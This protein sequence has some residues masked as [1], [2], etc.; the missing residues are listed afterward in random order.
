MAEMSDLKVVV[1]GLPFEATV[2]D[3]VEHFGIRENQLNLPVWSDSGR[4]KGVGFITCDHAEQKEE[5]ERFDGTQFTASD[6]T[7]ELSIR[8][9][10]E[11]PPR[12]GAQRGGG[13]KRRGRGGRGGGTRGS[14]PGAQSY[15]ANEETEREIYVS[16]ASF[17]TT[18][19][20]FIQFFKDCGE[21]EEVTIPTLYSTGKPKGFAFVRFATVDARNKALDKNGVQLDG[22]AL[23]IRENKGRAQ[24]ATR[25]MNERR[26]T[27]LSSKPPGCTTIYV[28]N[29]PWSTEEKDLQEMFEDCGEIKSKRIVRQS[30]T[31]RSRGF[32]YVEFEEEASVDTAV[33]KQLTVD[34]RDLRL[35]YAE[36]LNVN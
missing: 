24:R 5:I 33:Q 26:A 17:D 21:V 20:G 14:G 22:R 19:D 11:R 15:T 13:S 34:G 18:K 7:R 6:N 10:E 3:V 29:L 31:K 9:Y 8:D 4:C 16:N 23:G 27:G 30:W 2:E 36:N 32:G 25:S 35:D 28:G 1:R 12:R